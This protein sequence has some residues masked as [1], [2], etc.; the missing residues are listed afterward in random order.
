MG[1]GDLEKEVQKCLEMVALSRVFDIE[2]LWEVLGEVGR[3]SP[4]TEEPNP[5]S[6]QEIGIENAIEGPSEGDKTPENPPE[7]IDSDQ[8]EELSPIKERPLKPALPS[9]PLSP[10]KEAEDEGTE[11]IIIDNMT[12]IINELFSRK[13]K[14]DGT[15]PLLPSNSSPLYAN[16]HN[17]THPPNPPLPRPTLPN[18]HLQHPYNPP[19]QHHSRKIFLLIPLYN[20][21]SPKPTTATNFGVHE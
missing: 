12:H 1:N 4:L 8:E 14:T 17:S 2:G 6:P 13:E 20:D 10:R 19:Q 15:Y 21:W 16:N 11:I 18:P 3:S 9:K 5:P 7:I